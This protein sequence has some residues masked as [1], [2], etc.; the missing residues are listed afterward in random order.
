MVKRLLYLFSWAIASCF[1]FMA[2]MGFVASIPS[3]FLIMAIWGL[4]FLPP[5]YRRLTGRYGWKR[6]VA[7]RLVAFFVTPILIISAMPPAPHARVPAE[8][9]FTKTFAVPPSPLTVAAVR[10]QTSLSPTPSIA[11]T[12]ALPSPAPL[13]ASP[14]AEQETPPRKIS[15]SIVTAPEPTPEPSVQPTVKPI[16]RSTNTDESVQKSAVLDA[17]LKPLPENRSPSVESISPPTAQVSTYEAPKTNPLTANLN[18]PI[19]AATSGQGCD[20]PYD[21][22]R[23][24]GSCGRR[25]AYSRPGG[26]SP[27]C[28]V[29]DQ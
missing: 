9:S 25:S 6:N 11:P 18:D 7:G 27:I 2:L 23:R 17:E 20:C 8:Q 28:Y 24:G 12:K 1:F 22:D 26:R 19:R 15:E 21:R 3:M 14:A 16:N 10:P 4:V 29:G 13:V 5:L